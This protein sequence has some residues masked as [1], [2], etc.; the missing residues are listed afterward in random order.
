QIKDA[1]HAATALTCS[2]GVAPNKMLAK[3]SSELDKPDGLTILTPEDI[4][5]R[6][7]PLPA[8]KINGIGPR[9]PRSWRHWASRPWPTWHV[10]HL[11]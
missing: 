6:I 7:W 4:E 8:R 11:K 5:R 1:V 3:I 9:P 2:V 10:H